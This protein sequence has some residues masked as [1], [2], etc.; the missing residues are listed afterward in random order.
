M[1]DKKKKVT[2]GILAGLTTFSVTL[3]ALFESAEE[4]KQNYPKTPKAVIESINDYSEDNL[5]NSEV[6]DSFKE[7]LKKLIYRIPVKIRTIFFVPLWAIGHILISLLEI[8]FQN[9]FIPIV[10]QIGG[11]LVETVIILLVVAICIKIM[12]PDMPWSKIFSRKFI[13]SVLIGSLVIRI[14]DLVLPH[15]IDNYKTYRMII[16]FVIGLIA[17]GIILK[18]FIK[19]KLENRISYEIVYDTKMFE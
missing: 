7:R 8:L 19:K 9:I 12:F 14:V 17:T 3:G 5:E 6:H 15:F 10:S 4:L 13:L 16:K 1:M 2:L 11:F 18:P